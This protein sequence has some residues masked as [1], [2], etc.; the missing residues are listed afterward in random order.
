V[1]RIGLRHPRDALEDALPPS[2]E[3]LQAAPEV[4]ETLREIGVLVALHLA[5]ALAV[6]LTLQAFSA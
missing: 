4:G 5:F 1:N 6:A 2:Q 3:A